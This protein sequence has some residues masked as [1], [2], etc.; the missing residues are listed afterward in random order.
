MHTRAAPA[1]VRARLLADAE[2]AE[3]RRL[4]CALLECQA[5]RLARRLRA[6][7]ALDAAAAQEALAQDVRTRPALETLFNI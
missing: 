7:D 4:A 6:F 3:A 1:Q 5:Q 2:E